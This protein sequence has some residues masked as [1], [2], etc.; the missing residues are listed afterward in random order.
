MFSC[1]NSHWRFAA[2]SGHKGQQ[3]I[4]NRRKVPWTITKLNKLN[5]VISS[6]ICLFCRWQKICLSIVIIGPRIHSVLHLRIHLL[7]VCL[8]FFSIFQKIFENLLR[9]ETLSHFCSKEKKNIYQVTTYIWKKR[10]SWVTQKAR[11]HCIS[12][13]II[14]WG[15]PSILAHFKVKRG[16]ISVSKQ[17]RVL[18]GNR[19][20]NSGTPVWNFCTLQHPPPRF[21]HAQGQETPL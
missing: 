3:C 10:I 14:S 11:C 19:N 8:L 6:N 4:H 15:E 9:V 12:I 5:S 20:I 13:S 2:P 17:S 1:S 16:P 21:P 18:A 7:T